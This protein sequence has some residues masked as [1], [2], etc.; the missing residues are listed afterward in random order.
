MAVLVKVYLL[1]LGRVVAPFTSELELRAGKEV[2]GGGT[3]SS[4][5]EHISR[6]VAVTFEVAFKS[7]KPSIRV[8]SSKVA[9]QFITRESWGN[10]V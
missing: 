10:I 3:D 6:M 1:L 4:Q 9:K 7:K 5:L 8:L 2:A